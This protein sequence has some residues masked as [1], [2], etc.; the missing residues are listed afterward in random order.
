MSI[1]KPIETR[2]ANLARHETNKAIALAETQKNIKA[3]IKI[4]NP[5]LDAAEVIIRGAIEIYERAS[6]SDRQL[7]EIDAGDTVN[8]I[9]NL[10]QILDGLHGIYRLPYVDLA[11]RIEMLDRE[12]IP[13]AVREVLSLESGQEKL[14][15][16]E[17]AI[18]ELRDGHK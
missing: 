6:I 4:I 12:L 15:A 18:Q 13:F 5:M 3:I 8:A 1:L 9:N 7:G 10:R 2:L 17:A 14:D 11:I 16:I